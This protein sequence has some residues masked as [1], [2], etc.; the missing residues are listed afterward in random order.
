[1]HR[2]TQHFLSTSVELHTSARPNTVVLIHAQ[3][4][5]IS[6]VCE[7]V[8]VFLCPFC[9]FVVHFLLVASFFASGV[10]HRQGVPVH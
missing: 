10:A 8:P 5:S 9:I 4:Q 7:S 3:I 6:L 1:M 2:H